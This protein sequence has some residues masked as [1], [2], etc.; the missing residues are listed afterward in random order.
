MVSEFENEGALEIARVQSLSLV[1][2]LYSPIIYDLNK[3]VTL[4]EFI[5]KISKLFQ[6]YKKN[7]NMADYL[8][9]NINQANIVLAV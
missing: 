7:P 1:G 6:N 3:N 2:D 5:T 9:R 4:D 8:V